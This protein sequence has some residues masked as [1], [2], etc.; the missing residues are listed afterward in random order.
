MHGTSHSL[1][2]RTWARACETDRAGVQDYYIRRTHF[3]LEAW[4]KAEATHKV[5]PTDAVVRQIGRVRG[6]A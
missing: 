6:H 1:F 3:T 4:A 5:N 2:S